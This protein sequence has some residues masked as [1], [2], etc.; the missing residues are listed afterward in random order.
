MLTSSGE[1]FDRNIKILSNNPTRQ[2][3]LGSNVTL[4]VITVPTE[5]VL[6]RMV[7]QKTQSR[8]L[9]V[10]ASMERLVVI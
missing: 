10:T 3:G 9:N 6:W 7:P 4:R 1:S 2:I 8:C 5:V